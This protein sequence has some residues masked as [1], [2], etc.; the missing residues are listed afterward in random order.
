MAEQRFDVI[1]VGAGPAGASLAQ[2]LACAG[3]EVALVEAQRFPRFKPCG[4]FMSPEVLPKL[5]DLGCFEEVRRR[6]AREVS[7][8]LLHARGARV[9]GRFVDVGRA[10][11]PFRYGWAIRREVFDSILLEAALR[12]GAVLP[13]E[14]ARVVRLLRAPGG[15]VEGV[16][17][18]EPG[19]A[20][21]ELRADF[22]V[23][24][25]GVRSAVARGLGV[26]RPTQWLDKVAFTTRYAGVDWSDAAEVHFLPHGFF[27]CAPVDSGLVSLNLVLDRVHLASS[28]LARDEV[29]EHWLARTPM[30]GKR[31]A[32]GT[33]VDAVRGIGSMAVTTTQQT[34]D[35]A[36]LVGDAAGYVDPVTGEGIYFAIAGSESLAEAL[37]LALRARRR[38]RA[39]LASYER[40]RRTEL[41]PRAKLATLLQRGMRHPRLVGAFVR[42]LAARPRLADLLV[43]LTGDYVP[44]REARRPSVVCAALFGRGGAW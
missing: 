15:A 41:D 26:A 14:R 32:R 4:E 2:R 22:T 20:L 3:F 1:V 36:A 11:A 18:R 9:R 13:F 39:Q 30:L 28:G 6:G 34:F 40:M 25:D 10:R 7:E 31:L 33:R 17:A 35:G 37:V 27:A 42:A 43:A 5:R 23:G 21:H 38:D 12:A 29:L 16:V 8:M 44:L 24:A 19:G